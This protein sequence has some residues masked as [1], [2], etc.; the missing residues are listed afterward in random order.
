[1]ENAVRELWNLSKDE[2]FREEVRA[3]D[4]DRRDRAAERMY[5]QQEGRQEGIQEGLKKTARAMLGKGLAVEVVEECTGLPRDEIE[6]L[7]GR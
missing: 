5:A 6:S 4:K 2:R 1:M 3:R 7:S